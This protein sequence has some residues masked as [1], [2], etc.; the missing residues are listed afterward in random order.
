[1]I[2][3]NKTNTVADIRFGLGAMRT[4]QFIEAML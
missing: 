2:Y 3:E 4:K 1:M